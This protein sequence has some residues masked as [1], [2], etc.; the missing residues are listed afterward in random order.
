MKRMIICFLVT[1]LAISL[2]LGGSGTALAEAPAAA[3]SEAS[4][5]DV[6]LNLIYSQ[7]EKLK[8]I[9]GEKIW[10]YIP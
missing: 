4:D 7:A 3:A 1:I 9:D 8:Q 6:Q 10:Y 5:I 2:T